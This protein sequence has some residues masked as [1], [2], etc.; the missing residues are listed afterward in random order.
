MQPANCLTVRDV[1]GDFLTHVY[2]GSRSVLIEDQAGPMGTIEA[3][4]D[5]VSSQLQRIAAEG[6]DQRAFLDQVVT[7][8]DEYRY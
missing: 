5:W 8:R 3:I 2:V 4:G 1:N 6:G 7:V